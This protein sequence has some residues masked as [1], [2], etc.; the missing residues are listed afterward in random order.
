[1]ENFEWKLL[2]YSKQANSKTKTHR[3]LN[4]CI[5]R[6]PAK[7]TSTGVSLVYDESETRETGWAVISFISRL[8]SVIIYILHV[9]GF[10]REHLKPV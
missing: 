10:H 9:A 2:C 3:E 7:D 6:N 1:M 5:Q 4:L 8:L